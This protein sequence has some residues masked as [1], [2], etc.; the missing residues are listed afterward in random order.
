[1]LRVFLTT[2]IRNKF[3]WPLLPS[4]VAKLTQ[5]VNVFIAESKISQFFGD[6]LLVLLLGF[7]NK[8]ITF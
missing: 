5:M 2:L 7:G 1:M 3:I 4:V 8:F 6:V